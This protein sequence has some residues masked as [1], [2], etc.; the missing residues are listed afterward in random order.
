MLYRRFSEGDRE[1]VRIAFRDIF[2]VSEL[3]Y[4]DSSAFDGPSIIGY[5]DEGVKA[6]VLLDGVPGPAAWE[7][8]FVGVDVE[9][10]G[11]GIATRLIKLVQ[12]VSE[13][14]WLKVLADNRKAITVY[15]SL[16]FDVTEEYSTENGDGVTMVWSRSE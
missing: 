14:L 8:A 3:E 15:K 10:R 13:S 16:G 7:I 12:E 5:T 6:F 9:H 4:Y 2:D 1:A 11:K